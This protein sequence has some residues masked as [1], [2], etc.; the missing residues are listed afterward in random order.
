[1]NNSISHDLSNID[2]LSFDEVQTICRNLLVKKLTEY[3]WQNESLKNNV[4]SFIKNCYFPISF[5][6]VNEERCSFSKDLKRKFYTSIGVAFVCMIVTPF[7]GKLWFLIFT[8]NII[9]VLAI[10]LA[11]Y[12]YIHSTKKAISS[13]IQITSSKDNLEDMI[14]QQFVSI[15]AFDSICKKT[16]INLNTKDDDSK[17]IRKIETEILRWFQELYSKEYIAYKKDDRKSNSDLMEDIDNILLRYGYKFIEYTSETADFFDANNANVESAKTTV[18]ALC[19][20]LDNGSVI[21][22]GHVVFPL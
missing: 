22:R 5:E 16:P 9:S 18:L 20:L 11:G 14:N 4:N 10:C 6:I 1:M 2:K 8:L 12:F 7:L 13:K 21:L 17:R 15:V 3:T 19:D